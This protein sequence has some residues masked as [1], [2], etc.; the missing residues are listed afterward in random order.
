M[1]TEVVLGPWVRLEGISISQL[2]L[3][4]KGVEPINPMSLSEKYSDG[5]AGSVPAPNLKM[6][7]TSVL[8]EAIPFIDGVAPKAGGASAW[9]SKGTP[10][11]YASSEA[12]VH[13]YEKTV[14]GDELD[15]VE[16]MSQFS[17]DRRDETWFTRR[18]VHRDAA[19]EGTANWAE[20]VKSFKEE[21][22]HTEDAFTP[23]IIGAR[24]AMKWDA[25]GMEIKVHGETW[26]DITVVLEEMKHRI[27]PKPLKNRTFPVIQVAATLS[28]TQEFIIVSIPINDFEKSPYAEYARDKSLVVAAYASVERIRV[29]PSNGDIEWIM[30]TTSEAGGFLKS[31]GWIQKMAMP[32]A[33]AKDVEMFM[34]WILTQRSQPAPASSSAPGSAD[35]ALPVA[36]EASSNRAPP[37]ISKD[38]EQPSIKRQ[39]TSDKTLPAPPPQ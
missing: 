1:A 33:I 15:K 11:K 16:G 38:G 2:P 35:K 28:G 21:H 4:G 29:L 37:P 36:P 22:A 39:D 8:T 14:K 18:S 17:A 3:G 12:P 30:G 27:E 7:V 20:F 23:T 9:M 13:L 24:Q 19:E 6:F 5:S 31:V 32:G 34:S 25:S 26:K 10:K